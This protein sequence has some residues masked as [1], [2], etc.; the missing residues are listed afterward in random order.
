MVRVT[1]NP[2]NYKIQQSAIW[3]LKIAIEES[4]RAEEEIHIILVRFLKS[5]KKKQNIK[6]D[7]LFVNKKYSSLFP[8]SLGKKRKILLKY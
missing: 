7:P 2:E 4:L 1:F 3:A 8:P 6:C 5:M